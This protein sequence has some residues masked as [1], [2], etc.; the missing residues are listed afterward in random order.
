M[1]LIKNITSILSF[2]LLFFLWDTFSLVSQV[3]TPKGVFKKKEPQR[4][5]CEPLKKWV[6]TLSVTLKF[7]RQEP[8]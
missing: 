6:R 8:Y 7:H 4:T 5:F 2:F 3:K 1:F